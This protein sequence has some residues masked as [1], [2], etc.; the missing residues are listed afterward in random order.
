MEN[1]PDDGNSELINTTKEFKRQQALFHAVNETAQVLLAAMDEE[2]FETSVLEGMRILSH[3]LNVDRGYIWQNE[4]RRGILH[5]AMRFEWQNDTGRHMNPVENKIVY[6]YTDIPTWEAKFLKGECINGPL[7]DMSQEERDRL[8]GHGMKSVFAIP[9]FIQNYFWGYVSFDDCRQERYLTEDELNILR[10]VSL[11]MVNAINRNQQLLKNR[12]AHYQRNNLLNTVNNVASILL[13]ADT[14]EFE[15][16]LI[17]CLAMMGDA[18]NAD[19]VYIW[20]NHMVDGRLH[21]TQ[22]FEW[23]EGAEP[24]QDNVYTIDI[25]YDD[26]I[27][28]WEE[29]LSSG[30]CVNGIVSEMNSVLQGQLSPQGILSILVVPVFLREKFWGFVGF[31]DCHRER[32]YTENE[33]SILRS[34]S[35]LIAHAMLRN[36]LTL[37]MRSTAVKLESA[38]EEAQAASRAKGNFLSNMSHEMRTPMNAI[39]GMTQIGKSASN[40][41]KKNYAFEKIEGASNHLLGVINDVLDMSKIEAGKFELIVVEFDFEKMLQKVINIISFRIE[42]KKQNFSLYLDP[43]IPQRLSGDDQRLA[44][45]ITNLLTNAVKFTPEQGTISLGAYFVNDE[46]RMCTVKVEVKD[47]GIG[48]SPEQQQRLFTIFEQAESSI[49]RKFGGTGLGL[50]IS[51]QI[52]QMMNGK[53]WV[54]SELNKGSTFEFTVQ[55]LRG[56]SG[57]RQIDEIT[58]LEEIRSFK[59]CRILLAEDVD[60]NREIVISLLEPA[61][62]EIDCAVNGAEAVNMYKASPEKYDLILMDMQ[63]PEIDG[64]EATRLIRKFES[65]NV[66]RPIPIIAMTANVFKE[67][68]QKC[69]EAGMNDHIGKPLDFDEVMKKLNHYL[70]SQS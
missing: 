66:S 31:D 2:N 30:Q 40:I 59:G 54:E 46:D 33:E 67:D 28:G 60:I 20:R 38:F 12:D 47:S 11:M 4:T 13:Q 34:G 49:S 61:E 43:K 56:D 69:V 8:L 65:A 45:V 58:P 48:I 55:L 53:I 5:Y 15:N 37:G 3:C 25:S 24:Q 9:V 39:I 23:S 63:M 70:P 1:Q 44:Q 22:L 42:E 68:V 18:V 62:I 27:P 26:N 36:D 57:E 14:D 7:N 64:L 29:K 41:E 10:S 51:K 16:A 32:E 21:C 52:V 50:A 19:R 35:L 17:R 6:P